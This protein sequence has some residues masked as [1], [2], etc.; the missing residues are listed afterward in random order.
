LTILK[1]K[2]TDS[3]AVDTIMNTVK[4]REV[5]EEEID[6]AAIGYLEEVRFFEEDHMNSLTTEDIHA[7]RRMVDAQVKI[8]Q[9]M[10]L[11]YEKYL[12]E[13]EDHGSKLPD[14]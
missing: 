7:M 13:R 4:F 12:R 11:C 1:K 10:V 9:R 2:Y 8:Y 6:Q 14:A 3:H 5:T